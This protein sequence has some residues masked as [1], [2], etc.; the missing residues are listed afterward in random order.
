MSLETRLHRRLNDRRVNRVNHRHEFFYASP[1]KLLTILGEMGLTDNLLDYVREP[2][3]H[4]DSDPRR[5]RPLAGT[6]TG[7][8]SWRN[9]WSMTSPRLSVTEDGAPV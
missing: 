4:R 8:N 3:A 7:K 5:H 1:A 9:G 6:T 2:E